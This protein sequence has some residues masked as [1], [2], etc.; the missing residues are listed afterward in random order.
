[1]DTH[2]RARDEGDRRQSLHKSTHSFR[3][4]KIFG[5]CFIDVVDLPFTATRT[6]PGRDTPLQTQRKKVTAQQVPA[7]QGH[8]PWQRTGTHF[9]GQGLAESTTINSF[10]SFS[11]TAASGQ[12]QC[13]TAP[14]LKMK[15]YKHPG[16]WS[17][18]KK[19][20][21]RFARDGP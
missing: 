9:N 16:P 15:Q 14:W 2:V 10:S 19:R 18:S 17:T 4:C 1:M 11:C 12:H 6:S 3:Y 7:G 13:A 8:E 20:G 21:H 5:R